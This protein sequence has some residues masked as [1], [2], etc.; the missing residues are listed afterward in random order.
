MF[1]QDWLDELHLSPKSRGK[2]KALMHRLFEKAMFWELIPV[3][4]NPMALV[5][6]QRASRRRKKPII[7]T[8]EQYFAV[9]GLLPEPYP[10][11]GGCGAMPRP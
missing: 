1:V 11:D 7:L 5:E 10:N 2:I 8:V 6:I 4:R 9:L 3:G